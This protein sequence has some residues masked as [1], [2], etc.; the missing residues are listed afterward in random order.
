MADGSRLV[1]I[2]RRP[3]ALAMLFCLSLPAAATAQ[4]K[5][6]GT[7]G[8][9]AARG[10][11][12][13]GTQVCDL[14]SKPKKEEGKYTSRGEVFAFVVHRPSQNRRSEVSFQIGYTFQKDSELR[15]T[16]GGRT[17]ELFTDGGGAWLRTAAEDGAMVAAM[18]AGNTMVVRGTSSRG[19]LT[20]DTYSLTGFTAAMNAVTKE[21][22][23]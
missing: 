2:L 14:W 13:N 7:F 11:T 18:K 23:A 4:E 5:D 12:E 9:W 1:N 21:C 20:T 16:I 17:F 8:D 10:Y 19:T 3:G 15:A 22:G 6:L